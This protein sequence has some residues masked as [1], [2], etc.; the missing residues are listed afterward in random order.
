MQGCSIRHEF[1]P[2]DSV[3]ARAYL[4]SRPEHF[5]PPGTRGFV[6]EKH[7]E[8]GS[9]LIEFE[10]GR[11]A[12]ANGDQVIPDRTGYPLRAENHPHEQG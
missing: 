11:L 10:G 6:R 7:V 12:R 1:E 5:I 8:N 9:Y 2:G 3:V 4:P